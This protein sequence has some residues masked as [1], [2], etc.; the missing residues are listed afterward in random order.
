L[1]ALGLVAMLLAPAAAPAAGAPQIGSAWTA[2]M[3]T[4]SG[5]LRAE[6]NPNGLTTTY[7]FSYLTE[8]AYQANLVA[9]EGGF[10]GAAKAPVGADPSIGS[11]LAFVTVSQSIASLTPDTAYRFRLQ[12]TNSGGTTVGLSRVFSTE[13]FAGTSILLDGRG[14]ELVSPAEK[15]GAEIQG[16]GQSFGGGVIQA[17]AQGSAL[18]YSSTSS[19]GADAGG[20]PVASQYVARRGVAGWANENV[21]EPTVSGAFGGEPD[22]VPFQLFAGD[23]ARALLLNGNRCG[24]GEPCPQSYALRDSGGGLTQSVAEPD[25]HLAAAAADLGQRVLSTCAAL[26]GDAIEIP[27]T[28]GCDP[29]QPNLYRWS[30]S[31]LSLVNLLPA[32]VQGTPGAALASQTGAISGDGARVYWTLGGN[33][34]LREGSSTMQVDLSAG[35]GGAFQTASADGAVAFFTKAGHLY[36]YDAPGGIATDLTPA[37][38]VTGVLGASGDGEYVYYLTTTGLF[39]HHGAT[40]AKVAAAAD[41]GNYP[42]AT[43]TARVTPDGT[44]LAFLSKES[45]TGYDNRDAGSGSPRSEVFLYDAIGATLTCASCNP[46]GERPV[47]DSTIPGASTNGGGPWALHAYKPRSLSDDGRRLFFDSADTIAVADT[48]KRPDVYEWEAQGAGS[49]VKPDGCIALISAGR[50]SEG[51]AFLD[52]SA[53][54]GDAF[55]LTSDSLVGADTGFADAYDAREGGGFAE[56]PKPIE[57]VGDACQ[58]LPSEPD[59][60]TPGTLVPSS[61]NPPLRLPPETVACKKGFVKKHGRCVKKK[62]RKRV[63][64]HGRG[65]RR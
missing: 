18:T 61:G 40:A 16:P 4:V 51:A 15:D 1:V 25:L 65:A 39:L 56:T 13:A 27:G 36:R 11:G 49:C 26:T 20:A 41:S 38:G 43:G 53:S 9:G 60:P 58:S 34:Y 54:G 52:A 57:C 48:A 59:D 28:E 17:A 6:A 44:H 21:T 29:T 37:G 35:G 23:L 46:T 14:W 45:L 47:G 42:P 31:G 24:V 19:F 7:H 8:V 63:R 2:G 5:G 33:L 12:A 55:F 64:K 50:N 30:S 22:G 32:A 62:H 3:G 10:T